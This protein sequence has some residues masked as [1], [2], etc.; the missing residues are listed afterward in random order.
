MGPGQRRTGGGRDLKGRGGEREYIGPGVERALV[1][2]SSDG[3]GAAAVVSTKSRA[4]IVRVV[5]V[6]IPARPS[7]LGAAE[8]PSL[9]EVKGG[10]D[11]GWKR[12]VF[13]ELPDIRPPGSHASNLMCELAA[14]RSRRP[15]A[16]RRKWGLWV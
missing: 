6:A 2:W 10:V 8:L 15:V 1:L 7:R 13:L 5:V 11:R 16:A 12:P 3:R 4:W 14:G 9:H